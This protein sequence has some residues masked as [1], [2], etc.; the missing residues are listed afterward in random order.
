MSSSCRHPSVPT[1][2]TTGHDQSSTGFARRVHRVSSALWSAAFAAASASLLLPCA[3]LAEDAFVEIQKVTPSAATNNTAVGNFRSVDVSGDWAVVGGGKV[4]VLYRHQG[5]TDNWGVVKELT[6]TGSAN[7]YPDGFGAS[8]TILGEVIA[9]GAPNSNYGL[10][11]AF[12]AGAVY[13]FRKD[14]GGANNW[15]QIEEVLAST[16]QPEGNRFGV[17]VDLSSFGLLVGAPQDSNG[18]TGP[19]FAQVFREDTNS[20]WGH[21]HTLVPSDGASND[22]FGFSVA[23]DNNIA[24]VGSLG[25]PDKKAYLYPVSVGGGGTEKTIPPQGGAD[26][27]GSFGVGIALQGTTLAISHHGAVEIFDRNAGGADNWGAV[28]SPIL[29]PSTSFGN[30][31]A[32]HGSTLLV[33]DLGYNGAQGKVSVYRAGGGARGTAWTFDADIFASDGV[34]GDFFSADVALDL[35][36]AIVGAPQDDN[37]EGSSAGAAYI[38]EDLPAIDLTLANSDGQSTIARGATTTYTIQVT[39]NSGD[40]VAGVLVESDILLGSVDTSLSSWTCAPDPGSTVATNCPA[41]G[42][43]GQIGSGVLVDLGAGESLTFLYEVATNAFNPAATLQNQARVTPPS[44]LVDSTPGDTEVLDT[45]TF[46]DEYDLFTAA[47]AST[48]TPNAGD[49]FV[50]TA[51]ISSNG[52][53]QGSAQLQI[54]LPPALTY[55]GAVLAG[56]EERGGSGPPCNAVSSR[57]GDSLAATCNTGLAPGQSVTY[58]VT[59]QVDAGFTGVATSRWNA[60]FFI[61]SDPNGDNNEVSVESFVGISPEIFSDG[62]ESGDVLAWQ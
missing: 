1:Q 22:S 36:T 46:V 52:P 44:P 59:L 14:E 9:V 39:N 41:S 18:N 51:S 13:V 2:L 12:N 15:G 34:A 25:W 49:T 31:L 56:G 50:V 10:P 24:V 21:T 35:D 54:F 5:G 16:F 62:F 38:F 40:D 48:D 19:G 37:G 60:H 29:G 42:T 20:V 55:V 43:H 61:G 26:T 7:V 53:S 45:N 30:A 32:V 8:A 11:E 4:F 57:G 23:F 58:D 33:G 6:P 3:A 47:E 17:D 28:G 27:P